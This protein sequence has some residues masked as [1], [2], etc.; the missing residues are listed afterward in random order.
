MYILFAW[1]QN[2]ISE[3][4][5]EPSGLDSLVKEKELEEKQKQLKAEK[6]KKPEPKKQDP[7]ETQALMQFE[8]VN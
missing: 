5:S 2:T 4:F 8:K 7:T 1:L 3:L 6:S